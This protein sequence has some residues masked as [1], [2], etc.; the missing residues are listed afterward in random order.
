MR[1]SF[2]AYNPFAPGSYI[3]ADKNQSYANT[4]REKRSSVMAKSL[5]GKG[6]PAFFKG[7]KMVRIMHCYMMSH[8]LLNNLSKVFTLDM[9]T[10][11]LKRCFHPDQ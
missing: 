1:I 5:M 7:Q 11:V 8:D 4:K 6:I 3:L 2:S 9:G 10:E